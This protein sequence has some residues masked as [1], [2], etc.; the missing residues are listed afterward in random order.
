MFRKFKVAPRDPAAAHTPSPS[1]QRHSCCQNGRMRYHL[2][3]CVVIAGSI[4]SRRPEVSH[5]SLWGRA[6]QALPLLARTIPHLS[7]VSGFP[8][9][10]MISISGL[11][12]GNDYDSGAKRSRPRKDTKAS[13]VGTRDTHRQSTYSI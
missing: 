8:R 4:C 12:A 2:W 9:I 3:K 13:V 7:F 6:R 1:G 5:P 11:M 10:S